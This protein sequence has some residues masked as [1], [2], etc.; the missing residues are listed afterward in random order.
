MDRHH[1]SRCAKATLCPMMLDQS[2]LHGV[3]A[4]DVTQPFHGH[5]VA[6][7]RLKRE[8]YAGAHGA[9][10]NDPIAR[11]AKQHR[12]GPAVAFGADHF[13]AHQSQVA[14]H[15][16]GNRLER[17]T[18]AY[19]QPLSVYVEQNIVAHR[20]FFRWLSLASLKYRYSG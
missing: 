6:P 13:S 12:A 5:H 11:P 16:I 1:D 19:L 15:V 2:L 17:G 18:S 9:V 3:Q 14:P 8:L 10:F 4:V 20:L 7:I